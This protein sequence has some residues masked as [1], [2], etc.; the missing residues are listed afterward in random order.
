MYRCNIKCASGRRCKKR[1]INSQNGLCTIHSNTP[2]NICKC[3]PK[4]KDRLTLSTLTCC[5]TYCKACISKSVFEDQWSSE[6][7]NAHVLK[8]PTCN[9]VLNNRDWTF[10]ENNIVDTYP[11]RRRII[12]YTYLSHDVYAK[13]YPYVDLDKYYSFDSLFTLQTYF[14]NYTD[15]SIIWANKI[16]IPM[17]TMHINIIQYERVEYYESRI[18]KNLYKFFMGDPYIKSLFPYLEKELMEYCWHPRRIKH[19]EDLDIM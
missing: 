6:F 9:I 8:C 19:I 1:I 10:L 3:I 4:L 2:C 16:Y 7:S 18:D 14:L 5:H 17:N 15:Y 13:L 12:Y 11:L